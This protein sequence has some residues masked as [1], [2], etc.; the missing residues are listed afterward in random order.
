MAP[1]VLAALSDL[2][3]QGGCDIPGADLDV[4]CV[5][6]LNLL[7]HLVEEY[8]ELAGLTTED[9]LQLLA[10]KLFVDSR[11]VRKPSTR[12]TPLSSDG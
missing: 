11:E 9:M 3:E 4:F 1:S 10:G 8:A 12:Q 2:L 5:A 6:T 7:A